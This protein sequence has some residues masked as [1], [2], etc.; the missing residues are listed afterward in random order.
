MKYLFILGR[1]IELSIA[2]VLSF[3]Q[4]TE[5]P[6]RRYVLNKNAILVDVD[7]HL[8]KNAIDRLGG[9][10]AI[11]GVVDFKKELLYSGTKN[12]M[13]YVIWNFSKDIDAFANE[14]KDKFREE[15]LKAT[16]KP[17][18]GN[19][20]SQ[21]GKIFRTLHS[22]LIDEQYFV[23]N[24]HIGRITQNCD[25]EELEKRDMEK[26]VR[27]E[28]LSISPR[29]AKIMINLSRLRYGKLVDPFC[30][31][32][33]ILYEALLQGLSVTGVD[34]DE[35]ALDGAKKNLEWGK[36]PEDKYKLIRADSKVVGIKSGDVI[37]TEPNLGTILKKM[38]TEE[39][40]EIILI[41]FEK[42]IVSVLN[43]LKKE[44]HGRIVFTAPYIKT[45]LGRKSCNIEEISF[46]TGLKLVEGS[47]PEYREDQVM[48]RE[49]FV[50]GGL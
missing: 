3:L 4:R 38:P 33:V 49:I 17:L 27:R 50:L 25:Y 39:E 12:K 14:I 23:F 32:G 40:A 42:L 18:T 8:D 34:I 41:K 11:G 10:I 22:K 9:V 46:R 6:A 48:G 44:V 21:D 15:R 5:N 31:I 2:E 20:E 19:I 29:L 36:F 16:R 28:S 7:K 35:T 45:R 26:P 47:F 30:G 37:V 1:N 13:N 43:N 24:E